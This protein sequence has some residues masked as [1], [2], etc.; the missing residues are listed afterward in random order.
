MEI[1]EFKN[2]SKFYF[3]Q[4]LYDNV[5]FTITSKD[6][7]AIVGNNGV[8]K[9]TLLKL[10]MDEE[11][12][13]DG[14]ITIEEEK[15]I[16]YFDQFGKIDMSKTVKELLDIPFEEVIKT[17]AELEELSSQF[18]NPDIDMESLM[19]KYS[20]VNDKFE[21]LGAYSYLTLQEEFSNVFGFTDKLQRKFSELSGGERQYIRLAISLFSQ[22]DLTILDEPLSFFDKKKIAWLTDFINKSHK[23]FLVISHNVDFIR[24]FANKILHVHNYTVTEYPCD[25]NSYIKEKKIKQQE[26][27]KNNRKKDEDIEKTTVAYEKKM[28]LL[29]RVNNK[30]S[31]AVILRRMER[32]LIRLSEE[33]I[34]F[35]PE[36]KYE[37]V[38][39]PEDI[40]TKERSIEGTLIELTDVYKEFPEKVLYKNVNLN[41]SSDS[42]ICLVGENGSGKSTLLKILLGEEKATSGDVFIHPNAKITYIAQDSSFTDERMSVA[43]YLQNKSGLSPDFVES[44]ID[45]L[46]NYEK[47]FQDKRIF[48]LS[49][50]EK[51]RLEIFANILSDSDI[52]I[53]DE[54]T[55]YMDDYSRTTI[56]SMLCAYDGAVVLVSHDKFLMRQLDFV[57]FDIRDKL[58]RE[59]ILG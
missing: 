51:K 11:L 21:S 20:A 33:K 6:K 23:A 59:K 50:G 7:A 41:I 34:E 54:P 44:A 53:I 47:E 15:S 27:R 43:S 32:E 10:I 19:D 28:R 17:Q 9:S 42:K 58:I 2:V 45:T 36:Y 12:P 25:F 46:F 57:T 22:K 8:G 1:L 48:M 29:E 24:S 55:T 49:G 35:S 13:D 31:Q 40:Y 4:K 26:E 3:T 18:T 30:H 14:E 16:E 5:N 38:A 56:A 52:L 39:R 37:Y